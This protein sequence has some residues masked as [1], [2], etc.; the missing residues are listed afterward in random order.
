MNSLIDKPPSAI[1][2]YIMTIR[3]VLNTLITS[4]LCLACLLIATPNYAEELCFRETCEWGQTLHTVTGPLGRE[5]N[6]VWLGTDRCRLDRGYY[7]NEFKVD[8]TSGSS[9]REKHENGSSTGNKLIKACEQSDRV[10]FNG[11]NTARVEQ[12]DGHFVDSESR[13]RGWFEY[14]IHL[15]LDG[16]RIHNLCSNRFDS[17]VS[18][19]PFNDCEDEFHISLAS[20]DPGLQS[21]LKEAKDF[22]EELQQNRRAAE[23]EFNEK[24]DEVQA[25]IDSIADFPLDSFTRVHISQS[26]KALDLYDALRM[27]YNELLRESNQQRNQLQESL[28]ET[29]N[30]I[31][32]ALIDSGYQPQDFQVNENFSPIRINIPDS[33]QE[34]GFTLENNIYQQY[35]DDVL[36]ELMFQYEG[37]DFPA[38]IA[39]A[40]EWVASI[41]EFR[42]IL[43]DLA[44]QSPTEWKAFNDA[45]YQVDGYIF[46]NEIHPAILDRDLWFSD[47]PVT[48]SQRQAIGH[49]KSA[50]PMEGGIIEDEVR[51]WRGKTVTQR[52]L[53][54]LLALEALGNGIK[55]LLV[56]D[57][58]PSKSLSSIVSGAAISVKDASVC[59]TK[60][61]VTGD[62][63]DFY[64]VVIGKDLCTG[65]AL[66][67]TERVVSSAGF[68]VGNGRFW[69]KVVKTPGLLPTTK[70]L[71]NK[72][73]KL[74]K[75]K[76]FP[77]RLSR[78]DLGEHLGSGGNKD[79]FAY[80]ESQAVGILKPGKKTK[81]LIDELILLNKLDELGLPTVNASGPIKIDDSLAL[82]FDR[83][84]QGSKEIVRRDGNR[85]KIVGSSKLLNQNSIDDLN[86]IKNILIEKQVQI[87]DLQFLIS[88]TGRVVI[89]DPLDVDDKSP[90]SRN[91]LRTINLLI[92]AAEDNL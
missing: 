69:R 84:A 10:L 63:G 12:I 28:S 67:F 29:Q 47:S 43:Q 57:E 49:I 2:E 35:A 60:V 25:A 74:F 7:V 18:N 37:G 81:I 66:G 36:E 70:T 41:D 15:E 79:V 78:S 32:N 53:E 56:R 24:L 45:F 68:I 6:Q 33:I 34:N 50:Y 82:L 52:Q 5:S 73:I 91:N 38:F 4:M 71:I 39:T 22:I 3:Q 76:K 26:E 61:I 86:K 85:V 17:L 54:M 89:S 40:D 13:Q 80:G 83:F 8:R 20:L 55:E 87:D 23:V 16:E 31:E 59:A 19:S 21:R 62:F 65:K 27:E 88:S 14:E 90:P 30:I 58:T 51:T 64:E 72:V 42:Q 11:D 48:V 44:F 9:D 92:K 75:G 77:K 1:A 46:G